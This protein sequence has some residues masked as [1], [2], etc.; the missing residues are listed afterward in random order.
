MEIF[1]GHLERA[2]RPEYR[3]VG[4]DRVSESQGREM[5]ESP[6]SSFIIISLYLLNLFGS[7]D[8]IQISVKSLLRIYFELSFQFELSDERISYSWKH[9]QV[10]AKAQ[11]SARSVKCR[12]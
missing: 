5:S 10:N 3:R 2:T 6:N 7:D 12:I 4:L 11:F 1:G 9:F 8:T